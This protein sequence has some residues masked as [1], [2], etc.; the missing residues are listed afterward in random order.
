MKRKGITLE[1]R[2]AVLIREFILY[3]HHTSACAS[4]NIQA[5]LMVGSF[6]FFP[7]L[8]FAIHLYS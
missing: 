8:D 7:A 1:A 5:V 2:G 4:Y 3:H 6:F